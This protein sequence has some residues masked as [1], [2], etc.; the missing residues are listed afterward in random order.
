M[1]ISLRPVHVAVTAR[2]AVDKSKAEKN[3]IVSFISNVMLK[4][5]KFTASKL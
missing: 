1:T 3:A 5:Q 4:R 2:A